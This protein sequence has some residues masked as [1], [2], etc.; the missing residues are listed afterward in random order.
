MIRVKL[1]IY[2]DDNSTNTKNIASKPIHKFADFASEYEKFKISEIIGK[3]LI[4]TNYEI[5]NSKFA[6]PNN[7]KCT[8]LYFKINDI[9]GFAYSGSKVLMSQCERYKDYFPFEATIIKGKNNRL[10]FT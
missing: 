4:F 5:S 6:K 1:G 3:P 9:N 7:T 10:Y 2:E 8:K